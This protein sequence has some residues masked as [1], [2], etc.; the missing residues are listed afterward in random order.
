MKVAK[1]SSAQ[2]LNLALDSVVM[3]MRGTEFTVTSVPSG[4]LLVVCTNGDVV[5]TDEN[6]KELH[7][8]PATAVERLV[9]MGFTARPLDGLTPTIFEKVGKKSASQL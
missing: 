4:D 5:L 8:T 7:A 2:E 3:G 9:G 1:L 6:G